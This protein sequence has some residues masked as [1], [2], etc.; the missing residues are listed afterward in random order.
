[1]GGNDASG[2]ITTPVID[3]STT[4]DT[5]TK[6]GMTAT[7]DA[8]DSGQ[9]AD[10][11]ADAAHD[12]TADALADAE[13]DADATTDGAH[14]D[15]MSDGSSTDGT[16]D[17]MPDGSGTDAT[18]DAPTLDSP[19]DVS[20][21]DSAPSDGGCAASDM[22][23]LCDKYLAD[24]VGM[25]PPPCTATELIAF[26]VD[27]TGDCFYCLARAGQC[28]DNPD[29]S[30]GTSGVECEDTG[31]VTGETTSE[32]LAVLSCDLGVNPASTTAA[33][34]TTGPGPAQGY[35]GTVAVPQCENGT[36]PNGV[37]K[38]QIA[39]GFPSSFSPSQIGANISNAMYASGRAGAM[40]GCAQI[41]CMMC[42]R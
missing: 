38:T 28:L 1:M 25:P 9:A 3:S 32:C 24:T 2:D 8:A 29:P 4:P 41:S 13:A 5:S 17:A 12:A 23:C 11:G 34:S 21:E 19:A 10:A 30:V 16:T 20:E 14:A 42:L 6:D 27:H 26:E 15:A 31:L 37:C 18:N 33:V 7:T 22:Q 35:C 39:A 36:T 40:I